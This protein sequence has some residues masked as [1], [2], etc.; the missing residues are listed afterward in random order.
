MSF[1]IQNP[2]LACLV[3]R[4]VFYKRAFI[5]ALGRIALPTK[6][7]PD[8]CQANFHDSITLQQHSYKRA[9]PIAIITYMKIP[10]QA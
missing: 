6:P 5:E 2:N 3:I 4:L 1:R 10:S 9:K 7:G 8:T